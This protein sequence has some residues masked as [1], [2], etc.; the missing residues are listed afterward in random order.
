MN[1]WRIVLI[2][3]SFASAPYFMLEAC[4]A[5]PKTTVMAWPAPK[6]PS[7]IHSLQYLLRARGFAVKVD[8]QFG[9]QTRRQVIKFQ[10]S[11]HLK[12]D[13]VVGAETWKALI[14]Q[15]KKGNRGNAVRAVQ[16]LYQSEFDWPLTGGIF[17]TKTENWVR[18][19][20]RTSSLKP[21]GIVGPITW[22]ALL[23]AASEPNPDDG[24]LQ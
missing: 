23:I 5:A 1:I 18:D 19:F 16:T 4:V 8:G 9:S 20:Q 15:V 10:R 17:G 7:V 22:K 24:E 13:G 3:I 14:I 11:R 2:S 6:A 21:D 12:A